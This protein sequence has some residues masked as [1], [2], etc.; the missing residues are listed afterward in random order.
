MKENVNSIEIVKA[1]YEKNFNAGYEGNEKNEGMERIYQAMPKHV[2]KREEIFGDDKLHIIRHTASHIMAQAVKRLF[3]NTK[4]AIGPAVKDGFYYD[5]EF[6]FPL[7][8]DHLNEINN[9]MEKIIKENHALKRFTLPREEAISFIKER[10]EPYKLELINDI[11]DTEDISFY[12]QGEF[13]DLCAG[14]HIENT[15]EI[16]VFKLMM[17]SGSYW[18][19]DENNSRLTR[20]YGTAFPDKK[21]LDE[22]LFYLEEAERRDHRKLGKE[23]KLFALMEEGPGFPLFLPKGLILKNILI[24]YWR[25][26]HEREGYIEIS[27]PLLLDKSLWE[28]SGHLDYYSENMYMSKIDGRDFVIKPMNCPGGM[29]FYKM[30]PHSYKELPMRIAELGIDH[31]YEKSGTLHGLMRV[32]SFM[33]DDAHIYMLEEQITDE[34]KNVMALIDEVYIKF[35]FTYHVELSTMPEKHIGSKE[36]WEMAEAR[37][38]AAL[39]DSNMDYIV[40][41]GDGAFYG[42]K[43]DFHL[44]DSLGR[45]WQCG[46]IQLD[47]QLPLRFK[48]EYIAAD[49]SKKRPIMI[50][51]V[52]YGSIERF[53]GILIEH[54]AGKFPFWL[55][56]VQVKLLPISERYHK[57][58][59]EVE[60]KLKDRGI[61]CEIDL[62]DEKLNYKI[63]EA[64]LD[65]VP[66]MMIIGGKEEETNTVSIRSREAGDLGIMGIDEFFMLEENIAAH[67]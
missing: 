33:Q 22:H 21:S 23:L 13:I 44:M 8:P 53:I 67:C 49:G 41:E 16:K 32:R 20:I 25:R 36:E 9:E 29:L 59:K 12:Q 4:L 65:K 64:Q 31:R 14:P 6:D 1:S 24:D 58:V 27:T 66:Y 39:D 19:G 17:F 43:I 3:P 40:N 60:K 54:Y 37:L 52:V 10:N 2:K 56:P 51:R 47:F 61:R 42:P 62:R 50:H 55:A 35:G 38:K 7:N 34:I 5:F 46:S 11:P 63:R 48:A 45:T 26:I 30:Q 28:T 15:G 57:Y 18:R